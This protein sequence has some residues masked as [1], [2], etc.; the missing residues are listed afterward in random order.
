MQQIEPNKR[1]FTG[2]I[3]SELAILQVH[4]VDDFG[5]RLERCPIAGVLRANSARQIPRLRRF[6]P[7]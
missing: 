6:A 5:D 4:V 3:P 2:F 1:A 7:K